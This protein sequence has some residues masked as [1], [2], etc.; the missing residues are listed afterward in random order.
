MTSL[1]K[2][3]P[4]NFKFWE[5]ED[6]LSSNENS[7]PPPA[8]HFSPM[9][10]DSPQ[11]DIVMDMNSPSAERQPKGG[12]N[13]LRREITTISKNA[14]NPIRKPYELDASSVNQPTNT[15]NPPKNFAGREL[16]AVNPSEGVGQFKSND[17]STP[18]G[19]SQNTPL[20]NSGIN[21]SNPA[22]Q[23]ANPS[24]LAYG[25]SLQKNQAFQFSN[26][27]N[28]SEIETPLKSPEANQLQTEIA[29]AQRQLKDLQNNGRQDYKTAG[30]LASDK[31]AFI[32]PASPNQDFQNQSRPLVQPKVPKPAPKSA[33]PSTDFDSFAQKL[34]QQ[35]F[36]G[37]RPSQKI[38]EATVSDRGQAPFRPKA[39]Q[40]PKAQ[41]RRV[42]PWNRFPD[43]INSFDD[44]SAVRNTSNEVD[45]P[46]SILYGKSSYAPGSTKMLIPK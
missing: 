45:L 7:P 10:M 1:T 44:K 40:I 38:L 8:R 11:Q 20:A 19:T 23:G 27:N 41:Q 28:S 3:Q 46:P 13:D 9:P 25:G 14:S 29:E 16:P 6:K 26:P 37:I 5:T 2:P 4:K 17:F 21:G 36:Q 18:R 30:P 24:L 34:P 39:L 33:Y 22:A 15:N 31:S 43:A 12:I 32:R 35:D 42:L